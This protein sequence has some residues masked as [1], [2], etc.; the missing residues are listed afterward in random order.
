M[1]Y[2][3]AQL[4]EAGQQLS[5]EAKDFATSSEVAEIIST[6][7]KESGFS[8]EQA[9][10]ADSEIL[11]ALLGLQ[12]LD[13]SMKNIASVVKKPVEELNP[14]KSKLRTDIFDK[15]TEIELAHP[16]K[17]VAEKKPVVQTTSLIPEIA[18]EIHPMIEPGEVARDIPHKEQA[19]TP[20]VPPSPIEKQAPV[21]VPAP[22][23]VSTS[24]VAQ[25]TQ[26]PKAPT[27][28]STYSG[29]VDPYR[30]PIE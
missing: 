10:D 4:K 27:P 17:D 23:P 22:T 16:K 14:L 6:H 9:D 30:E 20:V 24:P 3:N 8:G 2:T 19:L 18:P 29:G 25:T 21:S 26:K 28:N 1:T 12:T 5:P 11:Y 13:D 7:L 15:L